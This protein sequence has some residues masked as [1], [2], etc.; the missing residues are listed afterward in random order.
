MCV[1]VL[2]RAGVNFTREEVG[3]W[4][5]LQDCSALVFTVCGDQICVHFKVKT[6]NVL[7]RE[8]LTK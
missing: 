2:E 3:A 4:G 7:C 6:K 5:Y 1:C 8:S